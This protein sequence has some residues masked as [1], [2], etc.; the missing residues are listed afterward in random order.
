MKAVAVFLFIIAGITALSAIAMVAGG[1][2][3]FVSFVMAVIY[4]LMGVWT[5]NAG[6]AF[7]D[8][9]TTEGHDVDLLMSANKAL[10]SLYTLQ[11][12]LFIAAIVI[13]GISSLVVGLMSSQ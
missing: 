3:Y 10:L 5:L 11:F 12:W 1:G 13:I 9:T 2:N 4:V 7:K 6:K 8:I